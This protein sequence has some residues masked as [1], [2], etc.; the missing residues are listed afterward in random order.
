MDLGLE[1]SLNIYIENPL[2]L[3]VWTTSILGQNLYKVNGFSPNTLK[4]KGRPS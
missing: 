3:D 4:R 2:E 1:K